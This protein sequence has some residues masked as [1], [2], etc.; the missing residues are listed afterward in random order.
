MTDIIIQAPNETAMRQAF[1]DLGLP[2]DVLGENGQPTSKKN[3]HWGNTLSNEQGKRDG[4]YAISYFG[5]V[6]DKSTSTGTTQDEFGNTV[7]TYDYLP[8]VYAYIRWNTGQPEGPHWT[9][10]Q[11]RGVSAY[12]RSDNTDGPVDSEGNPTAQPL[13]DWFPRIG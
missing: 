9:A 11:G 10:T 4:E 3:D 5:Q 8:G 1:G 12:W 7:N 13:P 6:L 2:N